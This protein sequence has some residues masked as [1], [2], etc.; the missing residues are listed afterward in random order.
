M[1]TTTHV[2]ALIRA[3][4]GLTVSELARRLGA[5]RSTIRWCLASLARHGWAHAEIRR[6]ERRKKGPAQA[7]HWFPTP[8]LRATPYRG[9]AYLDTTQRV[10]DAVGDDFRTVAELAGALNRPIRTVENAVH[11]LIKAGRVD[12]AKRGRTLLIARP[13]EPDPVPDT[14]W[15][16]PYAS[17]AA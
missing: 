2:A 14:P 13:L 4:D 11:R 3:A 5:R 8:K 17:T 1:T 15:R 10:L 7:P 9:V 16:H 12:H 6:V